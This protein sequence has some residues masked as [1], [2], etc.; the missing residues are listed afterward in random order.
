MKKFFNKIF[1]F[2]A[3]IILGVFGSEELLENAV[4]AA[5]ISFF[6]LCGLLIFYFIF[7]VLKFTY[8]SLLDILTAFCVVL[9]WFSAFFTERGANMGYGYAYSSYFSLSVIFFACLLIMNSI[10]F[11][12]KS[13]KKFFKKHSDE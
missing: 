4:V 1:V 11:I 12:I 2:H 7:R 8:I 6:G 13:L 10:V 5:S 3:L 9:F